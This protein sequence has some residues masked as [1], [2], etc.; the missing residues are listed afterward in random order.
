MRSEDR[1]T[2]LEVAQWVLTHRNNRRTIRRLAGTEENYL[3]FIRE[4]ERVESQ[5]LRA[6][7][8]HA[9][10]TLTV[11]EWLETLNRFH[12]HCAYCRSRPFQVM[13]HRLPLIEGGTTLRNC[14]PACYH[15]CRSRK[16][17]DEPV[18]NCKTERS[19]E[20]GE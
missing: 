4:L 14:V 1:Q 13:S 12:W 11:V 2:L 20:K 6:R 10:A 3:L 19:L 16:K 18:E 17:G 8:L 15:C 5:Y 7:T 9:E